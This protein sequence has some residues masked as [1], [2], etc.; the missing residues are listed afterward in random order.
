[1]YTFYNVT[2]YRR[3]RNSCGGL[4]GPGWALRL[5][6]TLS[7]IL[8]KIIEFVKSSFGS[9]FMSEQR[10]DCAPPVVRLTQMRSRFLACLNE[11]PH[12]IDMSRH[13]S[14]A[15]AYFLYTQKEFPIQTKKDAAH[16]REQHLLYLHYVWFIRPSFSHAHYP[17]QTVEYIRP[18][19]PSRR[20]HD[21]SWHRTPEPSPGIPQD[22]RS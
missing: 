20:Q 9:N 18:V 14:F 2:E 19:L 1:M 17:H 7:T 13:R 10:F 3:L 4:P 22:S 5:A 12:E 15:N 8:D 16:S 21:W 6:F 11:R